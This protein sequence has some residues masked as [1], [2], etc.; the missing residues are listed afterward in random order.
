MKTI[1]IPVGNG[2]VLQRQITEVQRDDLKNIISW[3]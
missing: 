1:D 3:A 2:P